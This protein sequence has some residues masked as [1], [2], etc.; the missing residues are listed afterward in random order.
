MS[1]EELHEGAIGVIEM[2]TLFGSGVDACCHSHLCVLRL[3]A[4]HGAH[5]MKVQCQRQVASFEPTELSAVLREKARVPSVT[6]LVVGF[7]A[8]TD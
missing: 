8:R 3:V 5:V 6:G 1:L 7:T 4:L 2:H